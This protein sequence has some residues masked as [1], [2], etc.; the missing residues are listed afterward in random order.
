MIAST[1]TS[2]DDG[3]LGVVE[4][5]HAADPSGGG[6]AAT[7]GGA[8]GS[9]SYMW[10]SWKSSACSGDNVAMKSSVLPAWYDDEKFITAARAA[11]GKKRTRTLS[12]STFTRRVRRALAVRW[13]G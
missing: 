9:G 13:A 2:V 10:S 3:L 12:K 11:R 7:S 8:I 5:N 6:D 4:E 1:S